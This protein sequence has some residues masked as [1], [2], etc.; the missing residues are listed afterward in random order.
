MWLLAIGL[1]RADDVLVTDFRP[2][3]TG[4][5]PLAALVSETVASEI[6]TIDGVHVVPLD[7]V[8]PVH[9]TPVSMYLASRPHGEEAGCAFVVAEVASASYAIAG[10]V[11]SKGERSRVDASIVD[12]L[13][14][15]E[16]LH[17]EFDL[18]A[19]DERRFAESIASL[20]SGVLQGELGRSE[21]IRGLP[22]PEE[23]ARAEAERQTLL[24]S[25]TADLD[26]E[27]TDVHVEPRPARQVSSLDM[28][29]RRERARGRAGQILWRPFLGFA[30]G[31]VDAEY[32][33]RY[34]RDSSG[35]TFVVSES[36]SYQA[37]VGGSG[38]LVG[39]DVA[40]GVLPWLD[41]G[42]EG[43]LVSGSYRVD[44]GVED[45]GDVV[46][47]PEDFRSASLVIGPKVLAA[48][49]PTSTVRPLIGGTALWWIGRPVQAHVETPEETGTFPR[50]STWSIAAVAGAEARV[51]R[52]VDLFVHI[53]LGVAIADDT[54]VRHDGTGALADTPAPPSLDPFV[55][56]VLAGVQVRIRP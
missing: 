18:A 10:S 3:D 28:A 42:I 54:P 48:L 37:T 33:G 26:R 34:A 35:G 4:A 11:S 19:G 5:E 39:S 13:G 52:T 31:P 36:Y 24:Q 40:Y 17:L 23:R 43:G 51:S 44:I 16:I 32:F 46:T 2:R 8:G 20:L 30:Q 50:P 12:V 41:V 49:F 21:D 6:A 47:R 53:P 14:S 55:V 25:L 45:G 56:G 9:D 22:S 15:E 1:A 38:A 7:A 27:L 29:E